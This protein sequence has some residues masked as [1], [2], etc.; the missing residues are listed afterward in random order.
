MKISMR[1]IVPFAVTCIML[2]VFVLLLCV[3]GTA[4]AHKLCESL[5]VQL[6]GNLEFVSEEDVRGYLDRHYGVYIGVKLDSLDLGRMERELLK[7]KVVKDAQ[8]WTT[9]D[10]VLHVSVSQRAPVVRFQRG[11]EGFYMD[12]EGYVFPLHS[13]YTADVPV[14]EG[15][16]PP[17]ES[18]KV[19][20]WGKGVLDL[21][22]YI[23]GSKVWKDRISKVSVN[24]SGDIELKP[25]E[26]KER[27]IFGTPDA[28]QDKFSR[29]EKYYTH[30][31]PSLDSTKREGYYKS[32]N[33]KYNKQIICRKDI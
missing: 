22:N 7:K 28:L 2:A 21:M 16:I 3:V 4:R 15:A 26:G 5:D 19:D 27:F 14:I 9:R 33:L 8:A 25:A 10:G 23:S 6:P 11:T 29:M 17:L 1:H 13:S 12:R 30:I 20:D 24:A 31:L 18:G 32:V